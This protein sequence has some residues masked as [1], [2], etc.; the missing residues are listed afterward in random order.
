[1]IRKLH[2]LIATMAIFSGIAAADDHIGDFR[3]VVMFKFKP[4]A[5]AAQIKHIEEEFGKLPS[6]IDTIIDYEWGTSQTI[7]EGLDQGYTH[8]FIVTF[9][10]KAGLE[11][12]L[13]HAEHQAFVAQIKPMIEAVHV[14]DFVASK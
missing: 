4:D 11:A 13:P 3:H 1:M 2:A 14:F 10:E 9:K 8:C 12:Y 5:T 6:K 7:E